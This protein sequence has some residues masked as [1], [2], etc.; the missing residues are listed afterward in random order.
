[1]TS[2]A[3][4]TVS[5][6]QPATGAAEIGTPSTAPVTASIPTPP[7]GMPVSMTMPAA[8]AP[9]A[10]MT[11]DGHGSVPPP[12]YPGHTSL[13]PPPVPYGVS[14]HPSH[15]SHAMPVYPHA[16]P[17]GLTTT[18]S[19]HHVP[20]SHALP[21]PLSHSHPH[22][23]SQVHSHPPPPPHSH[24]HPAALHPSHALQHSHAPPHGH[25]IVAPNAQHP[26]LPAP[27]HELGLRDA[28]HGAP[29]MCAIPV[30]SHG[31]YYETPVAKIVRLEAE[32]E[33]ARREIDLL[34]ARLAETEKDRKPDG[35]KVQSRY[36][37]PHEHQRFLE[38]LA[39]FGPKDV[40][41]IA[42][43]VGSR[44]AT[45]VRTHAQKYFLRVARERKNGSALQSARRRSM[46]ESDLARVGRSVRTPPGSPPNRHADNDV[47]KADGRDGGDLRN[48]DIKREGSPTSQNDVSM[49]DRH[50]G[51]RNSDELMPKNGGLRGMRV[52]STG[53]LPALVAAATGSPS[54]SPRNSHRGHLDNEAVNM[55]NTA[56]FALGA[57]RH[58]DDDDEMNPVDDYSKK[59]EDYEGDTGTDVHD[60]D[61]SARSDE[62]IN[63]QTT[64]ASVRMPPLPPPSSKS[65]TYVSASKPPVGLGKVDTAGINL[66]SLV[67]SERKME[68]ESGM[69]G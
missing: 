43:Y 57:R 26:H 33:A 3:P 60:M 59:P 52:A 51:M 67:A 9:N 66:L 13:Q 2:S 42:T 28:T 58:T 8:A 12:R 41:A 50:D 30:P 39:K 4:E 63:Y 65:V 18:H 49:S 20:H 23:H 16:M 22:P 29:A 36:W 27:S 47:G 62:Y 14:A 40:R 56:P 54:V 25:A 55:P 68:T 11:M 17:L 61:T 35:P 44:N 69:A 34:R 5:T 46:S 64:N 45:Q 31:S 7:G 48:E 1:M 15:P 24:Q 53:A 6:I 21:H 32:L 37:T 38:A 10:Y 19:Q